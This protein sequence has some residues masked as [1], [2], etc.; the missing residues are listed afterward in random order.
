MGAILQFGVE[1]HWR[2]G[3]NGPRGLPKMQLKSNGTGVRPYIPQSVHSRAL[4]LTT[5]VPFVH[6]GSLATLVV[7]QELRLLRR[8][9]KSTAL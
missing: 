3:H 7:I 2:R 6:A 8:H 1:Q 5:F 4:L 9:S